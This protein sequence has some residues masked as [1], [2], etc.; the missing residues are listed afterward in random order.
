MRLRDAAAYRKDRGVEPKWVGRGRRAGVDEHAVLVVLHDARFDG[1]LEHVAAQ[2]RSAGFV[3]V[4]LT[5]V[6]CKIGPEREREIDQRSIGAAAAI[7]A[8][9]RVDAISE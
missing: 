9:T 5:D 8:E 3:H 4:P 7:G 6:P 2:V 1:D